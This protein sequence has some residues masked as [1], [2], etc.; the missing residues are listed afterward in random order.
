VVA[1]DKGTATFSDLANEVA[2]SYNFWLGD[3]FAS[4]GSTGYDHKAMGITARGAWASVRHHFAELGVDVDHDEITVIGIG[5]MSGDVFGNGMLLSRHLRL[6]AA[7]D[8]RHVFLD[9]D[10]DPEVSF[11]E[12]QRL[13]GL[14]GSTWSDYQRAA[15]SAGGGIFPRAAK[16]IP[17]SVQM[18][19]RLGVEEAELPPAEVIRAVL[20]AP[21]DLLWN[22]GVGT[23][24]K[25]DTETNT[26]AADPAN[27]LVRVDASTL[28]CRVI[29]EGG[30]LGVTRRGRIAFADRGGRINTDFI[31]NAAGVNISDHEVNL[32]ILL[33]A[34]VSRGEMDRTERNNLLSTVAADV[35]GDV[36][37]DNELQANAIS[38]AQAQSARDLNRYARLI[39]NLEAETKLDR[40]LES[41]PD[42]KEFAARQRAGQQLPRPDIAV[43]LAHS[44]NLVRAELLRSDLPADPYLAS[45]LQRYFP[46]AVVARCRPWLADHPLAREI[47]AT[48]LSNDLVN[49]LGPG[50]IY[51]IQER[52]GACTADI[53]RAYRI[54]RDVFTRSGDQ[55]QVGGEESAWGL[56]HAE[57]SRDLL[58]FLEHT[59]SWL[60]R[61]RRHTMNVSAEV[62]RF[63][64]PV[65]R[66]RSRLP[67]LLTGAQTDRLNERAE[68][69][70]ELGVREQVA[71]TTAALAPLTAA[72]DI[73]ELSGMLA[74]NLDLVA[75]V[76][77]AVSDTLG[78]D[79]LEAQIVDG[80]RDSH[81]ERAA[82]AGM[83]DDVSMQRRRLAASVLRFTAAGDTVQMLGDWLAD[84]TRRVDRCRRVLRDLADKGEVDLS[85][86]SVALHEVGILTRTGG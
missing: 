42:E 81:W 9:P 43:L 1:A 18:R 32:K 5:D 29:A 46:A 52:T 6:V 63:S 25:A 3:A 51:R 83:R 16:A 61:S 79:S 57:V 31:D 72:L 53:A 22:G 76:Y 45:E 85:M 48:R 75:S 30:N 15:L 34:A 71:V 19:R 77:F 64:Q 24:I 20:R 80:P 23:Y 33:D 60:L 2:A 54:V 49:T 37:R 36:L 17:L 56:I 68:Q 40:A 10:P 28:R 47:I 74:R 44:K 13:F 70:L 11:A 27:D 66:L 69:L 41:L 78:L 67:T 26:D 82:K 84:N 59:L 35:I 39:R 14:P 8:H 65:G 21:V 58:L 50:F 7:F 73:V 86:L 55:A 38:A 12:R 4:G 62:A